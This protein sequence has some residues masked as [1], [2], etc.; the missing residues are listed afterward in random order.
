[1]NENKP[2]INY[3]SPDL[4]KMK[5][6]IID[7]KTVIYIPIDADPEAAKEAYLLRVNAKKP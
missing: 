5:K 7:A 4:S 3:A 2:V 1:M 6:V